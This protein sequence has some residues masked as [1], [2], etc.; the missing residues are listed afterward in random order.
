[1]PGAKESVSWGV[2]PLLGQDALFVQWDGGGGYGDPIDRRP[3]AVLADY[4][5][6]TVTAAVAERV[7]GV[8]LDEDGRTV[9]DGAT[10]AKRGELRAQRLMQAAE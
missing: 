7:F 1:M 5:A 3:E 10:D 6:G 9:D 2:Y 8:V 4:D